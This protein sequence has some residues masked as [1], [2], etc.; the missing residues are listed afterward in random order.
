MATVS[1]AGW[2]GDGVNNPTLASATRRPYVISRTL[3]VADI[4][5]AKGSGLATNDV[6]EV[7]NVPKGT[8][9][10][11]SW[12]KKS[13]AISGTASAL[14]LSLGITGVSATA[15]ASAYDYYA[16]ST[17]EISTSS[18][19]T[20]TIQPSAQDTIDLLI[21]G[22]TGT[23]TGGTI[24]VSALLVEVDEVARPGVAQPKS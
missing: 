21:A 7:L 19:A 1:M 16:A 9:I 14:T 4:V 22:L 24:T 8:A 2:T 6:I 15:W 5:T 17:Y 18:A 20:V 12:V 11:A 3:N 13:S 23:W 10:L